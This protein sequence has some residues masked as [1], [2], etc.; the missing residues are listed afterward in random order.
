MKS[1]CEEVQG[2]KGLRSGVKKQVKTLIQGL[3][4]RDLELKSGCK[5]VQ[6]DFKAYYTFMHSTFQSK[7]KSEHTDGQTEIR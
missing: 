1:G 6:G 7:V 2:L 4:D 5:R 3:S